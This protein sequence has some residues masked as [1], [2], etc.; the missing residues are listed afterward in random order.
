MFTLSSLIAQAEGGRVQI[1][2]TDIVVE[3]VERNRT[4]PSMPKNTHLTEVEPD[5]PKCVQVDT[6]RG[7]YTVDKG[8]S[9][10]FISR[11]A[12]GIPTIELV[13]LRGVAMDSARSGPLYRWLTTVVDTACD[14][15][16]DVRPGHGGRMAQAGL[17]LGPRHARVLGWAVSYKKKLTTQAMVSHDEDVIGATS[18]VW[19][20]AR[21]Q[22]P[23][24]IT[25][26]IQTTLNSLKMPRLATR[27]VEQGSGYSIEADGNYYTF[28]MI[29]RAPPEAYVSRGYVAWAHTDPAYCPFALSLCVGRNVCPSEPTLL[30]DGGA[31]FVDASLHVIVKQDVATL[32]AFKPDFLHGTTLAHGAIN[33]SITIA[34]SQRLSDAWEQAGEGFE[35]KSAPGAGEGNPDTVVTETGE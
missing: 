33:Y 5:R 9:V 28:P 6:S 23:G 24:D 8:S 32:M 34:F 17:N 31:N 14:V 26:P 3:I 18:L 12:D 30:P 10:I 27:N 29:E 11:D 15:R 19:S 7:Y 13:V 21:A 20:L 22:L 4:T 35:V 1:P 2:N 25:G 16:S